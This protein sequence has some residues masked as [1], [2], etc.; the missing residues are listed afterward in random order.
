MKKD[1]EDANTM[2]YSLSK[3][4]KKK[5]QKHIQ[6]QDVPLSNSR[7]IASIYCKLLKTAQE[8]RAAI[9]GMCLNDTT[10]HLRMFCASI[11]YIMLLRRNHKCLVSSINLRWWRLLPYILLFL[12]S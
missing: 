4:K 6:Y 9:L 7:C 8:F 1:T 10:A 11:C 12:L 2:H 5:N 3:K